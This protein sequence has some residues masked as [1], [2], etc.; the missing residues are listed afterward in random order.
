M[1]SALVLVERGEAALGIVYATDALISKKVKIVARFPPESHAAIQYP[2]VLVDI[3][4]TAASQAFYDYLQ[5][6]A[7]K[8][9]FQRFGFQV[10]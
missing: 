2:M 5:S 1:R 9:I 8:T 6:P 10:N 3:K 4:P 7:A